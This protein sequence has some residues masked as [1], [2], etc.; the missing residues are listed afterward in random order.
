MFAVG[1]LSAQIGGRA[2]WYVPA[3]FV[4]IMGIG[5]FVGTD[6]IFVDYQPIL[7]MPVKLCV[8]ISVFVLGMAIHHGETFPL[9]LAMAMVALFG[10]CHG[11]MHGYGSNFAVSYFKYAAGF[12]T[13]TAGIHLFGVVIGFEATKTE[14]RRQMLHHSGIVIALIGVAILLYNMGDVAE[15]IRTLPQMLEELSPEPY[16]IQ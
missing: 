2:V 4:T 5:S 13:S 11:F 14:K 15:Y 3:S 8:V 1:I 10:F 6:L 16:R 9:K 12:M 7:W